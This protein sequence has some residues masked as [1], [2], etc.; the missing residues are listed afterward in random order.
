M[1]DGALFLN[2]ELLLSS[3]PSEVAL[4]PDGQGNDMVVL[5]LALLHGLEDH[6]HRLEAPPV[7]ARLVPGGLYRQKCG[8]LQRDVAEGL[9]RGVE[10]EFFVLLILLVPLLALVVDHRKPPGH[11]G[12]S[13]LPPL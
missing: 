2:E 13:R 11:S 12:R 3:R 4:G 1:G 7:V 5:T 10:L 9:A 8:L 6:P